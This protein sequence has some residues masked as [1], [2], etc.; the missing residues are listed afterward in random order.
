MGYRS[1]ARRNRAI[2][3]GLPASRTSKSSRV[4]VVTS[5][6]SRSATVTNTRTVSLPPRK[7]DDR[8]QPII[9]R[10]AVKIPAVTS[11]AETSLASSKSQARQFLISQDLIEQRHITDALVFELSKCEVPVIRER[12]LSHLINI[13]A[14]LASSVAEG[15]GIDKLPKAAKPVRKEK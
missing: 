14:D 15:L 5:R 7:G 1:K 3:C 8:G 9:R 13:D 11:L 2:A 6:P 10:V 12:M 4:R